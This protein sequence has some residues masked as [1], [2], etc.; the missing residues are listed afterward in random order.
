MCADAD[1]DTAY[2]YGY[3]KSNRSKRTRT[4]NA[5]SIHRSD[6]DTWCFSSSVAWQSFEVVPNV[7]EPTSSTC[8]RVVHQP[9]VVHYYVFCVFPSIMYNKCS[10]PA[11]HHNYSLPPLPSPPLPPL[12]TSV[13]PSLSFL[14][15]PP[16]P[17]ITGVSNCDKVGQN[18]I[19]PL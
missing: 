2:G 16:C 19:M 8:E 6:V 5:R 11:L 3:G 4:Q 10:L 17:T 7:I 13:P 18:A 15:L 14:P 1:T 9:A 12:P